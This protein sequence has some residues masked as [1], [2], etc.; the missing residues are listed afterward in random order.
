MKDAFGNILKIGDTIILTVSRKSHYLTSGT[1]LEIN[2]NTGMINV[3]YMSTVKTKWID[4][5]NGTYK[6]IPRQ[7]SLEDKI[8]LCKDCVGNSVKPKS[9]V[10]F[11]QNSTNEPISKGIVDKIESN[12]W[13]Y[14]TNGKKI[15]T[16]GIFVL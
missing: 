7:N 16:E 3:M 6:Y 12:V 13:V 5:S 9:E 1:I 15:R 8:S 14:L 2:E 4:P 10:I 11:R